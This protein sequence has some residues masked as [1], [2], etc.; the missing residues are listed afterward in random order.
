MSKVNKTKGLE[1]ELEE[2]KNNPRN[3]IHITVSGL[4]ASGKSRMAYIIKK[5]LAEEG[6]NITHRIGPDF[7]DENQ[8]DDHMASGIENISREFKETKRI[9]IREIPLSRTI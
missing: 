4:S 1:T 7:A 5:M 6:F 8:F 9:F 3:E 2:A